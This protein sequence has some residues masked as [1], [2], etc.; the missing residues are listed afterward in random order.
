[1]KGLVIGG[2]DLPHLTKI[3]PDVMAHAIS[4]PGLGTR[5]QFEADQPVRP[6]REQLKRLDESEENNRMLVRG[7]AGTGKTL[8]AVE[9]ALRQ[10]ERGGKVSNENGLIFA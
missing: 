2:Q 3:L 5:I 4:E 1:M 9:A 6:D 7:S 8:L 10:A